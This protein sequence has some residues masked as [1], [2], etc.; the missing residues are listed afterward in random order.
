M[1]NSSTH[2]V[3]FAVELTPEVKTKLLSYQDKLNLIAATPVRADNFHI[4][5]SFL[6]DVSESKI[7]QI[8]D[9]MNGFTEAAFSIQID[10]PVYFSKDK[11]LALSIIQINSELKRLKTH[12]ENELRNISH[13]DILKREYK[14]HISLFRNIEEEIHSLPLFNQKYLVNSFCLMASTPTKDS[15]RY[16]VI[17]EWSFSNTKSIK[18]QLLGLS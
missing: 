1:K 10:S 14:P 2:R 5:L 11:I 16:D 15:V 12:I 7:E 18:H 6:G 17:E 9:H 8:L 13:F 3:F 4:T